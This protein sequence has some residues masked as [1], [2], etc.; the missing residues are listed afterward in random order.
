MNWNSTEPPKDR[1]IMRW[2]VVWKCA[3]PVFW[4]NQKHIQEGGC[5]WIAGTKNCTWPEDSFSPEW[6]EC[7]GPPSLPIKE[8]P[9]CTKPERKLECHAY[10][11]GECMCSFQCRD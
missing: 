9:K 8:S 4:S 11:N 6:A 5:P 7:P 3:I 1:M 10:N 2:H